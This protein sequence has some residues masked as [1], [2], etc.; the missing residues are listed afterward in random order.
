MADMPDDRPPGL[1]DV[2]WLRRHLGDPSVVV[3]EVGA[4]DTSYHEGHVPGA[5]PLSWLDDLNER[6]RRGVP[7]ARHVELLLGQRGVA[8]DSHVVL[9]GDNDNVFAAYAYWTLRYYGHPRVSL[10]DGGRRAW[11]SAR[12]PLSDAAPDRGPTRYVAHDADDSI[13]LT[14]ED[15]LD[16]YLGAPGTT[17]LVDC[18][19]DLEF[20]GRPATALDLPVLRHR[21][22]G[23]IPGARNL[24]S[25]ALLDRATGLLR[26]PAELRRL[27]A[28]Q[29][30]GPDQDIALYC[31][32]G[33]RSA[34]T[35]IVLHD[36]L[37]FPRVRLYEGGWAEYGSLV[38]APVSR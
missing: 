4:D 1:V 16:S 7:S 18:R 38:A 21:L 13:R 14:R 6:D 3:V 29:C 26:P 20:R 5:S 34:L 12:G 24:A 36:V 37:G 25:T 17:A 32:V 30:I 28:E 8:A 10:L 2:A 11:L 35:W 23:H 22:G 27:F 9:Y 31:D 19:S 33:G 15:V